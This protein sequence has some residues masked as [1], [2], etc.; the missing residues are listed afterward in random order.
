MPL[1]PTRSGISLEANPASVA[2]TG[3]PLRWICSVVFGVE[4]PP[5]FPDV[6]DLTTSVASPGPGG[7]C[8]RSLMIIPAEGASLL[9]LGAPNLDA[10]A[11]REV[12]GRCVGLPSYVT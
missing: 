5:G 4:R 2:A 10:A 8:S 6:A 7:L 3:G 9:L 12:A 1:R 11:V